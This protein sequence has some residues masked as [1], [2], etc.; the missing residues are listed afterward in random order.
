M[1]LRIVVADDE[2]L[3]RRRLVRL[4][5][6]EPDVE[7]V[8][9]CGDGVQAVEAI[10]RHAPQLAFLDIEMPGL[11][12]FE[13]AA[14][15]ADVPRLAIVFVTAHPT[16]ALR[17]FEVH[18]CDYLL[19][20]VDRERLHGAIAR[21]TSLVAPPVPGRAA[22]RILTLLEA[23]NTRDHPRGRERLVVRTPERSFL[24]RTESVDW[25]EA[26]GKI[27]HLHVGGAVH[28]LRE[29]MAE[30]ELALDATRFLRIS[31]SVIVN[32]DRIQE[33]QPWFQGDFVLI[34]TN[35]ARLT[36]TRGYRENMRKLLGLS[37]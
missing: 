2:T 5:Q 23:L 10:R 35:G 16:H 27:V 20:P 31:R 3:G 25:I 24:L 4:L 1:T 33:I 28:P 13:V 15:L 36:S 19:K 21:A 26:A 6:A 11:D 8:A 14:A 17:A 37:A 18:A 12:G 9:V 7:V 34:L 22:R 29:S 30:L 32:L